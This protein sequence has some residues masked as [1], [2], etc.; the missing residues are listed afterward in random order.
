MP[1]TADARPSGLTDAEMDAKVNMNG[2]IPPNLGKGKSMPIV[3]IELFEGRTLE[4][5]RTLVKNVTDA[6]VK[7][8]DV[9]PETVRIIL[10]EMSKDNMSVAGVLQS[11][12]KG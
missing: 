12:K 5:K 6:I 4:Q 1:C 3:H 8:V 2:A 7:S 9:K 10:S 11:D